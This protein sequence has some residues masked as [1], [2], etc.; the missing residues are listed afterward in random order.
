ML[1]K[2]LETQLGCEFSQQAYVRINED[3]EKSDFQNNREYC[4]ALKTD[5]VFMTMVEEAKDLRAQIRAFKQVE[6]GIAQKLMKLAV[7]LN[8][9]DRQKVDQI[10]LQLMPYK[11]VVSYKL[12]NALYLSESERKWAASFIDT[13]LEL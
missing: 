8:N 2:E 5:R 9:E 1:K 10:V 4:D 7:G 3:Y 13:A 6:T 12:W 11:E